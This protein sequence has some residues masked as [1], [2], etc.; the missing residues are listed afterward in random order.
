[1]AFYPITMNQVKQIHKLRAEGIGIKTIA[2][3]LGISKNTV[4]AYL[5]KTEELS[6]SDHDVVTADNPV[7]ADQLKPVSIQEQKNYQSFLQRA[8]YYVEELSNRKRTHVTRMILWEEDFKA[9]LISMRYS[10]FCFHLKRYLKS[11]HPSMVMVHRPGEKIFIDFAGDKLQYIDQIT[12]RSVL[13]EVLLI[14]LGYSNYTLAI[15]LPSQKKEDL[16]DGVVRLLS[17]LGA[18]TA[19][20]VPDNLKSAVTSAD[21]YEPVVNE[22]FLDMA[23]H[24]GVAVLPTRPV[25]PKDKAKVETHVN[26]IYQQV[27]ARLRHMTFR[28]LEELNQALR[29][30]VDMLNDA[31]MQDY[32]VSRRMLL[33]RDERSTLKPLPAHPYSL[34]KQSKPTVSV[35]GHVKVSSIGK[36]LSVPYRLIGQKVTVLISNGLARVYHQ[37]EC[38]ATH[39]ISGTGLYITQPDHMASVHREYLNSFSP[40][41]LKRQARLRGPEVE[42]LIEAVLNKGIF[43]EQMYKT[44]QGILALKCER[45]RFRQCCRW[46]LAN[47]LTSLRY[48]RHLVGSPHVNLEEGMVPKGNLP[49]HDNIRGPENYV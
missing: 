36:Y 34:V 43:P 49:S 45:D 24:Y 32:G 33:E 28:S 23:N 47:N 38:V 12:G 21:R 16:I 46:A 29:E 44:C 6:L 27:Y 17:W 13:V 37:R 31:V 9:G 20:L 7:L 22:T 30:K 25:K 19:A 35:N 4:K 48:M 14:T 8:D 1:M 5:R 10:Q 18:V 15:G 39:A 2:S 3:I 41:E 42:S 26:V 40:D 11:K